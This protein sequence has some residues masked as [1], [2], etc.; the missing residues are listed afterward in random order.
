MRIQPPLKR[1]ADG[2][3]ACWH[4]WRPGSM[5][6]Y[7]DF[8]EPS[9]VPVIRLTQAG[10]RARSQV[11]LTC[12]TSSAR[13]LYTAR[14]SQTRNVGGRREWTLEGRFYCFTTLAVLGRTAVARWNEKLQAFLT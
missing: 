1:A 12:R 13:A 4:L 14:Q 6:G 3:F 11:S 10:E 9:P 5:T 8:G 7:S 2:Q